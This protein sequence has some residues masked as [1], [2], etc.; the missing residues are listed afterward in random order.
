MLED[1]HS[2]VKWIQDHLQIDINTSLNLKSNKEQLK[3]ED[4]V[5]T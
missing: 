1:L 4:V 2:V 3:I 5:E